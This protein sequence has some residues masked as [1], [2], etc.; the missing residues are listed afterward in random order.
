ML[1]N[2][3][4]LSTYAYVECRY[5]LS[6]QN[7]ITSPITLDELIRMYPDA[8]CWESNRAQNSPHIEKSNFQTSR[9]NGIK[10]SEEIG[11]T[12][13]RAHN[14]GMLYIE[15]EEDEGQNQESP[16]LSGLTLQHFL[17]S[18]PFIRQTTSMQNSSLAQQNISEES[19]QKI[20]NTPSLFSSSSNRVNLFQNKNQAL[21]SSNNLVQNQRTFYK[22]GTNSETLA[23][24]SK[25]VINQN[26]S[27]HNDLISEDNAQINNSIQIESSS[28]SRPINSTISQGSS[29]FSRT[30]DN[31]SFGNSNINFKSGPIQ[32]QQ[33]VQTTLNFAPMS[34]INNRTHL[35]FPEN[36]NRI[37]PSSDFVQQNKL[38]PVMTYTQPISNQQQPNSGFS[39]LNKSLFLNQH[40]TPL[41]QSIFNVEPVQPLSKL[42]NS[43]NQQLERVKT[44]HID[45]QN[46][47]EVNPI[48][49]GLR[50]RIFN[51]LDLISDSK[52]PT[53]KKWNKTEMEGQYIILKSFENNNEQ[54]L[55]KLKEL[56]EKQKKFYSN[57]LKEFSM[58]FA[59]KHLY[60]SENAEYIIRTY[61]TKQNSNIGH[62]HENELKVI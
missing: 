7:L 17:K 33:K 2:D 31:K 39:S 36:E 29:F 16:T 45:I 1:T 50:N 53:I 62:K 12:P 19:T 37:P 41:N 51:Y 54:T 52:V 25:S 26:L 27:N 61:M 9:S 18:K 46:Q 6:T 34:T 44:S 60:L 15:E 58:D 20:D 30:N 35:Q 56:K 28:S 59:N 57:N 3:G 48:I 32:S 4:V 24:S 55:E 10:M 8:K 23:I 22:I 5:G 21:L 11:N 13:P 40:S 49:L 42:A 38:N 47:N 14:R 43:S